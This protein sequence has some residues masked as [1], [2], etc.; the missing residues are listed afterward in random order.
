LSV[1]TPEGIIDGY[2][3]ELFAVKSDRMSALLRDLRK[4]D[5]VLSCNAFGEYHHI[6]FKEDTPA[7]RDML[8]HILEREGYSGLECKSVRPTIEDCFIKLM[9]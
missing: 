3:Q 1:D 9:T 8:I 5:L 6:T 7:N 4:L 2:G